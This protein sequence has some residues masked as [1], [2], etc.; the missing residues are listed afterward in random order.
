MDT[1]LVYQKTDK[2]EEE[3][4][5]R[6]HGLSVGLRRILI[7]VDGTSTVQKILDKGAGLQDIVPSLAELEKEG[8][9]QAREADIA[10]IKDELINVARQTLGDD[11][12]KIVRKLK[13]APDTRDGLEAAISNCKKFVKLVIDEAKADELS[14]KCAKIL[15]RYKL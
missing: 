14:Q 9:I 2:G 6:T 11:A 1:G 10:S 4:R 5:S 12:E 13:E 15:E 3:I 8:F 7:L